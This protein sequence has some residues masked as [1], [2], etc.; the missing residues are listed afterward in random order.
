VGKEGKDRQNLTAGTA[1]GWHGKGLAIQQGS[2]LVLCRGKQVFSPK[3]ACNVPQLANS[4]K[5]T[6][7]P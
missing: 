6:L 3:P 4:P 1:L 7:I 5:K 2:E